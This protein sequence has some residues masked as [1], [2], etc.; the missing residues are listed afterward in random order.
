LLGDAA[1]AA[2]DAEA[3]RLV[4]EAGFIVLGRTNMTE[5][6]FSGLGI[7]P[8]HGTPANPRFAGE[9]RIPGGS[10][11]GAAV[12]VARDIVPVALGTDTGGSVRIPAA[13]CGLVGFK[14]TASSISTKGVLPLSTTLD[15]V[16][17]IA[18]RVEDCGRLFEILRTTRPNPP[19][20]ASK[21]LAVVEN[22][23]F[24]DC[25]PAVASA[26]AETLARL[27]DAGFEIERIR[28]PFLE[29]IAEAMHGGTFPGAEAFAWHRPFLAAG[30]RA[31]YDPRVV[32]RI[33]AGERV[34]AAAYSRLV[35]W[36]SEF[37]AEF[38]R[39]AAPFAALLWPTVPLIAPRIDELTEE[40]AYWRA[41]AL[42]LR[43]STIAN[44]ADGCALSLPCPG[45]LPAGLTLAAPG[46]ADDRL[47]ALA[48]AA[49]TA[50]N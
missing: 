48:R 35:A 1:P 11:S 36:R 22:Y 4:K 24:D 28:L 32:S 20:V 33:E 38:E 3:V 44:L 26:V 19:E 23:V 39:A 2:D 6:A 41:N 8:H 5:F 30:R 42:M 40:G 18:N 46:G 12:S 25:D 17:V 50:L 13:L 29:D 45:G 31:D 16:G 21:R 15:G 9:R 27:E 34:D 47:L 37:I 14:P 49:E 43:N 10:S 7:N